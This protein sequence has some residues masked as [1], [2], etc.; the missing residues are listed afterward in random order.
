MPTDA[1][2]LAALRFARHALGTR[3]EDLPPAAVR[4]AKTFLLDTLGVGVSAATDPNVAPLVQAVAGWGAGGE[5]AV[6]GRRECLPAPAA[7][8]IN[9]FQVHCQEYDCVH[10]AA[11]LHPMATLVPAALAWAERAGGVTGRAFLVALAIGVDVAIG[12]GLAARAGLRFFRP[13]TAGGFGATAAVARLAGLDEPALAG[14]FGLQYAQT[15]GTMQPHVEGSPALPLQIGCN[16]RAALAAC[17]L[18]QA[19]IAGP[20]DVFEGPFGYLPLFEGEWDL[21]PIWPTLGRLWRIAELS[22]KPYPAGRATHA[23]IEGVA[24]LRAAHGFTPADI[25]HITV[26][27]PP[28]VQRLCGRPA[29]PDP[30]PAYA[31][32][33]M[34]F[35]IA[36]RLQYGALDPTHYRGAAL[37]DP[38]TFALARRVTTL[39][40]G[41]PDPNAL[42]PQSVRVDLNDGTSVEWQCERMLANPARPLSPEQHLTKFRRCWSLAAAPLGPP[43][44]LID[45]VEHLEELDDMRALAALLAP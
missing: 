40:D 22:H 2:D 12:L 14:A 38:E 35:V 29:I 1:P 21:A 30:S 11:V 9:G 33:C 20:R 32:L 6:W 13:A 8:L 3:F 16:S 10:E 25:A 44:A 27:G 37:R 4:A 36:K 34:G 23:G 31:R 17:D 39:A 18:A 19:G 5:A 28:L 42:A 7:A 24:A 45:I 15:S 26:L 41:N 43:E